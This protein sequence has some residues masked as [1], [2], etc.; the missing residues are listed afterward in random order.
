M[1]KLKLKLYVKLHRIFF[2]FDRS[3]PQIPATE[4]NIEFMVTGDDFPAKSFKYRFDPTKQDLIR[5]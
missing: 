4:F 1:E 5:S 2:F 3:P